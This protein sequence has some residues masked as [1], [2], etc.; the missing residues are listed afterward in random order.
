MAS[1]C[2]FCRRALNRI[3]YCWMGVQLDYMRSNAFLPCRRSA[4]VCGIPA[5][6]SSGYFGWQVVIAPR[7]FS[8]IHD[9]RA[10]SWFYPNAYLMTCCSYSG[11]EYVIPRK[12]FRL[13]PHQQAGCWPVRSSI[14]FSIQR[15]E[16][17]LEK[18]AWGLPLLKRMTVGK[19]RTR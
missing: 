9:Q 4:V 18:W 11:E 6:S 13:R 16:C 19:P 8:R 12:G 5:S 15:E 14:H 2:S 7:R 10:E 1:T 3:Y 17:V